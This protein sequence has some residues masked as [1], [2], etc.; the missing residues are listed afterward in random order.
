MLERLV[1]LKE[2]VVSEVA[3]SNADVEYFLNTSGTSCFHMKA[4]FGCHRI[5]LVE[6][7]KKNYF[8]VEVHFERNLHKALK[9]RL[10]TY[11]LD[12]VNTLFTPIYTRL[13]DIFFQEDAV[14]DHGL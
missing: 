4:I 12:M 9:S 2:A 5:T 11:T 7:I 10:P 6:N 13:K 14:R 8:R 3:T 1:L